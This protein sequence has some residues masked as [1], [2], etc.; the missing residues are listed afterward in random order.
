MNTEER[1]FLMTPGM[2][3]WEEDYTLRGSLWNGV[4]RDLPDLP[5]GSRILELG[6]GNGKSVRSMIQR[7][8]EVTALDF[9]GTAV[10]LCRRVLEDSSH[11]QVLVADARRSPFRN[12]VF[13]AVFAV[14]VIAHLNAPDRKRLADEMIRLIR[15]G[16]SLFFCEFSTDDFRFGRG[17]ETEEATF[18][19][20]TGIITHYFCEKEVADLFPGM[21]PVSVHTRQWTMRVHG[22]RLLRSEIRAVFTK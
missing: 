16:G 12:A 19:R 13:D 17:L 22:T 4:I 1:D 20:G 15:P 21:F 14:H 3:A 11:G 8:W 18:R 2:R 7:G 6:C 5:S 9:S 10:E